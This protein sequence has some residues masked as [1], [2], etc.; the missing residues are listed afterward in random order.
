M[1]QLDIALGGMEID[2]VGG[3]I[4][5]SNITA[6]PVDIVVAGIVGIAGLPS[7]LAAVQ[8]GQTIAL[9]N[10]VTGVGWRAGDVRG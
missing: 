1:D 6:M 2:I 4:K 5:H 8:A 3:A 10:R 7:V 9:A